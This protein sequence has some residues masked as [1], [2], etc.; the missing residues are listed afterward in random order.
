MTIAVLFA[1]TAC[2]K[3]PDYEQRLDQARQLIAEEQYEEA[4]DLLDR[5]Y[6]IEYYART[7]AYS[8]Y[9]KARI[10]MQEDDEGHFDEALNLLE[11]INTSFFSAEELA[12]Y[13]ECRAI[14]EEKVNLETETYTYSEEEQSILDDLIKRAKERQEKEKAIKEK[15]SS[16]SKKKPKASN[17]SEYDLD[18]FVHPEDFYDWYKD[19]FVDL[20]DAENYWDE[21]QE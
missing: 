9:C 18:D 13:E 17:D 21:H 15:Q 6:G 11:D 3:E 2:R 12:E 14:L 4:Q 8:D 7:K 5:V 10:Y 19:D 20:E 16:N 1:I